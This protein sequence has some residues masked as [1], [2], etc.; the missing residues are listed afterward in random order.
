MHKFP[1]LVETEVH[2]S[3]LANR[4]ALGSLDK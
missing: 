1:L 2:G 4:L 3:A